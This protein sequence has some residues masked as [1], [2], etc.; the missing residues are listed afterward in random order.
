MKL[1]AI[2]F[3]L[4][5]L[6]IPTTALTEEKTQ[7]AVLNLENLGID[8]HVTLALS[9]RLRS[10]LLATNAYRVI[11]RN[12]MNDILKEQGLQQTGCTSDE[13]AV[14]IGKILNISRICAGSIG[15]VGSIYTV[16]LRLID[17]GTGEILVSVT[18]DCE[19]ALETL[20][21]ETMRKLAVQLA[22]D[23]LPPPP[24]EVGTISFI[25]PEPA[26]ELRLNGRPFEPPDS[27]VIMP[28]G[29]YTLISRKPGFEGF[30]KRFRLTTG[31]NRSIDLHMHPKS[32][33]KAVFRSFLLPGFGQH[34]Q[35][36]RFHGFILNVLFAGSVGAAVL[37]D[38]DINGKNE[39]Y[40]DINVSYSQAYSEI[41]IK[42]LRSSMD[43]AYDEI[44]N[45]VAKRNTAI[46]F[47]GI[48]WA[49]GIMDCLLR[50]PDYRRNISV[51]ADINGR[52]AYVNFSY[53][54]NR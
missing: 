25:N 17:V 13:C 20:L 47:A 53:S 27:A 48:I 39:T 18:E 38:K 1:S 43:Q 44:E 32:A 34:Y 24:P 50:E 15:K 45:L 40:Q 22:G 23:D 19:C 4:L 14:E 31:D 51:D 29:N 7:I 6:G 42:R 41:N 2:I 49:W 10:E 54:F 16:S 28:S 37:I 30:V 46:A 35:E 33:V 12:K 3:L 26:A 21:T 8:E 5:S 11:E 9:E 52:G 36:K